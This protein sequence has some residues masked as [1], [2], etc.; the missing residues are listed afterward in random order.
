M[1][2]FIYMI[3]LKPYLTFKLAI[4]SLLF[5]CGISSA[6]DF[7]FIDLFP[8][9]EGVGCYRIPAIISAPN[10]DLIT[11]IDERIPS[12]ADLRDNKNINLVLRRSSDDGK[13][14]TPIQRIV[15]YPMGQSASDP[16]M[17]VDRETNTIFMFFNYMD[18][19]REPNIYYLKYIKSEDNGKNLVTPSR[20]HL[21]NIQTTLAQRL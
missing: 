12:C 18:L 3:N 20:H 11:A 15:D 1:Q 17:I 10:G 7:D 6:Q 2:L 14:W 13:S 21:P 4:I 9:K 19:E 16:S 8:Q 5:S